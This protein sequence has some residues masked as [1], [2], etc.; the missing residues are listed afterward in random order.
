M[1]SIHFIDSALSRRN[2]P[3]NR[4]L[5]ITARY[6]IPNATILVAFTSSAWRS[7]V[8]ENLQACEVTV[9]DTG[10]KSE[11]VLVQ[12]TVVVDVAGLTVR[13][14]QGII[15]GLGVLGKVAVASVV[16]VSTLVD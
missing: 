8:H 10:V 9:V 15:V 13:T 14:S 5:P 11:E 1:E 3:H 2:S 16:S 12:V 7:S 4:I 6:I